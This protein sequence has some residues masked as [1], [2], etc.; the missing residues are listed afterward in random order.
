MLKTSRRLIAGVLALALSGAAFAPHATAQNASSELSSALGAVAEAANT[1]TTFT[2]NIAGRTYKVAV[3]DSF[4]PGT[5]TQVVLMFGGW[6]H[7]A[8]QTQGYAKLENYLASNTLVVYAEASLTD[9]LY[10]WGGAPYSNISVNG[11]VTYVRN[12]INDLVSRYG[13]NQHEIY[14]T[15]L[16]NGGGMAL[17]LG[18][19]APDLVAGV[20]GVAGAYYNPTVTNC[21]AGNVPTLI[22]HGTNDDTVAYNGGTRHGAPYQS[23]SQVFNTMANK[24]G[25][26]TTSSQREVGNT[27]VFN[28][29]N[30]SAPTQVVRVN[31]GGHTWFT[32]PSAS[33]QVATFFNN[34]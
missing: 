17:A 30:C 20:A 28:R 12:V 13:V 25:C 6:Q 7:S 32:D 31:G 19:H 22:M 10:A 34:L 18:C 33:Q 23:V 9:N 14:A 26:S 1:R 27:T 15:G 24:N 5:A 2:H 29:N 3:P 8:A 16:S 21:A 4:T 11:D